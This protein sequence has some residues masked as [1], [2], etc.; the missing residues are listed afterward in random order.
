MSCSACAIARRGKPRACQRQCLV[1]IRAYC[2]DESLWSEWPCNG[3]LQTDVR[4][5]SSE[6]VWLGSWQL[7]GCRYSYHFDSHHRRWCQFDGWDVWRNRCFRWCT[8]SAWAGRSRWLRRSC[9]W[10]GYRNKRR[11]SRDYTSPISWD[12]RWLVWM[13]HLR[14]RQLSWAGCFS[15]RTRYRCVRPGWNRQ[16]QLG[17]KLQSSRWSVGNTWWRWVS[18]AASEWTG[19]CLFGFN[20]QPLWYVRTVRWRAFVCRW[21]RSD[22]WPDCCAERIAYQRGRGFDLWS[23]CSK[24]TLVWRDVGRPWPTLSSNPRSHVFLR[25]RAGRKSFQCRPDLLGLRSIIWRVGAV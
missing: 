22:L 6:P 5:E 14:W 17:D 24:S 8:W 18:P 23:V 20:L 12:W 7:P 11:W 16:C 3:L 25:H 2:P 13:G 1:F 9:Y 10:A 4:S 21:F 19:W 15:C